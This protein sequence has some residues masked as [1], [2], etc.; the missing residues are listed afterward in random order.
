MR[1]QTVVPRRAVAPF[2]LTLL[3]AAGACTGGEKRVIQKNLPGALPKP[4]D[5]LS[6]EELYAF[7]KKLS[8]G[9]GAEQ[10]RKCKDSPECD[11]TKGAA[12]KRTT[13]RVD[14]V[15][16]QDSLSVPALPNAGV[17]AIQATNKGPFVDQM[18]GMKPDKKLE[19]YLVV[20]PASDTLGTWRLEELDTTPG[21]RRHSQVA[22][23]TFR[24]CGH[25]FVKNRVNRANFYT[26]ANSPQ[27]D[28]V[29]KSGLAFQGDDQPMWGTCAQGC[30]VAS[31]P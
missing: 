1:R 4:L 16:G 18:Y 9:G 11:S 31:S 13:V 30:C 20:Y 3:L 27:A 22:S 15:D 2:V 6:G 5:S 21:S 28:S 14:A 10:G 7:A 25:T 23:G 26:C 8:Y 12:T 17:I 24:P 19:Y 29:L